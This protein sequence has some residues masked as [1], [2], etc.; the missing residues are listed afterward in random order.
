M[1]FNQQPFSGLMGKIAQPSFP[2]IRAKNVQNLL[3]KVAIFKNS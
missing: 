3:V 1:L 2:Y